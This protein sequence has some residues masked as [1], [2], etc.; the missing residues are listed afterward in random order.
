MEHTFPVALRETLIYLTVAGLVIPLLGRWR[1]SN[2]LGFLV[3]GLLLG[4][5]GLGSLADTHPWLEPFVFSHLQAVQ[6]LAE[7]GVI[8]L[9]FMI[10]LDLSLDKLWEL[11]KWVFGAGSLQVLS[12]SAAIG[13]IAILYGNA[14][15]SSLILGFALSLSSTAVVMQ[16]MAEQG[17]SATPMGRHTF[18]LL[19]FQDLAVVP[20][21]IVVSVLIGESH[22][23]AW[24]RWAE[25]LLQAAALCITLLIIGRWLIRPLFKL[26]AFGRTPESFMALSLLIVVG[27]AAI[28]Q[29]AGMS[30]ALGAFL[31]GLVIAETEYRHEVEINV[32]P[33]KGLL[34]G[35][36]FMSVGMAIDLAHLL[37]QIWTVLYAVAGLF[38]VK[39]LLIAVIFR[40]M[41]RPL[42]EALQAGM[43]L[44]QAGEFAFLAVGAAAMGG[45]LQK[46]IS[47]FMLIVVSASLLVT[48]M[49][50]LMARRLARKLALRDQTRTPEQPASLPE[51]RAH[52]L[53]AGYG[54]VGEILGSTL[55]T[56]NIPFLAF[57]RS[58]DIIERKRHKKGKVFVGDVS[59]PELLRLA[60]ADRAAAI[61]LTMDHPQDILRA[62]K[63]IRSQL[64]DTPI[65]AR[66]HDRNHAAELHAAGATDIVPEALEAGLQ[67]TGLVLSEYGIT[68]ESRAR[69][70]DQQ[71]SLCSHRN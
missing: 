65:F 44:G 16:V 12:C 38:L 36:F 7:L 5:Y 53:I 70:L 71:R 61:V 55:S 14:W 4:P 11:R 29:L 42:S 34:M 31:A 13:G 1:I 15:Q 3:A 18:S 32:E 48:P 43:T 23:S 57:D 24:E 27:T 21:L 56:L 2:V 39:G 41:G 59:R 54:R 9:L 17:S 64:P 33:F 60:H 50:A 63:L 68:E 10:G 66:A 46:E 45:L 6:H 26:V 35:L 49:I 67:L 8:F 37:S 22:E 40:L 51:L 58:P 52:V 62:L 69:V 47:Q 30:P 25:P 20:L 19:L 28:T